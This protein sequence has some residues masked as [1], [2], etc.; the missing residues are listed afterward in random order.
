MNRTIKGATVRRFH[1]ESHDQ[2]RQHLADFVS[3]YNFGRSRRQYLWQGS[4][5]M[6]S[7]GSCGSAASEATRS[8]PKSS[9]VSG[10]V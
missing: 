5:R 7:G 8:K 3:A 2:L 10:T 4:F 9:T 6:T 1:Y